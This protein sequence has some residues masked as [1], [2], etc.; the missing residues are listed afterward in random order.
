MKLIKRYANRKLYDTERSCYVTLDEIADMVRD[1]DE[2]RIIDNRSG[3]DLTRVTLAQIVLEDEKRDKKILPLQTLRMLIEQP[4][5]MI[6]RLG[7]PVVEFREQTQ[8]QM[9]RLKRRAGAQQEEIVAP[10]REFVEGAQRSFDELQSRVDE[11]LKDTVDALTHVPDLAAELN[12]V[13]ARLER[14]ERELC[15][16]NAR[17]ARAERQLRAST[18]DLPD[19]RATTLP[20]PRT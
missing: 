4:G 16:T 9:E 13:V 10:M 5:E 8:Q 1:G 15:D 3:E 20:G 2:L 12:R 7:R 6:A 17:L 14:V 19:A 18:R 11:R